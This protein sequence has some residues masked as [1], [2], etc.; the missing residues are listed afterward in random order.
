MSVVRLMDGALPSSATERFAELSRPPG[1][2]WCEVEEVARV[3][4]NC[5]GHGYPG[6]RVGRGVRRRYTKL[7]KG[8]PA[9]D[10]L[11][12]SRQADLLKPYQSPDPSR[13]SSKRTRKR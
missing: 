13:V 5:D 8:V 12:L 4:G 3:M 7:T 9:R 11:S 6:I 1:I 2:A 10:L